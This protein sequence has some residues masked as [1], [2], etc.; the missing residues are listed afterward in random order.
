KINGT[1]GAVCW[2]NSKAAPSSNSGMENSARMRSTWPSFR[3]E[4]K[5]R[6][7]S[8]RRIAQESPPSVNSVSMRSVSCGSVSRCSTR[9]RVVMAESLGRTTA[10]GRRFVDDAPE[11]PQ[12]LDRGQKF[13]KLHGLDDVRVGSQGITVGQVTLF[14]R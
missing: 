1:S 12:L 11:R 4:V 10:F 9:N 2:A 3:A 6:R 13:V 14:S 8:T 7:L 5:A